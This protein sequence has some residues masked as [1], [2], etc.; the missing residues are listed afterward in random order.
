MYLSFDEWNVWYHSRQQDEET[1]KRDKWG[2]ALPLLEDIYNFEDALLVG[3]MLITLIRNS[4]RV[5]IACL[6]QLVNVIAPIMTEK[7]GGC[8]AQTIYWPFLHASLYGRGTAL[9]TLVESPHYDCRSRE[10]VPFVDAVAVRNEDGVTVFCVN[11]DM[12]EDCALSLDLR[13]FPALRIEEHILLHHDDV[14]AVNTSAAPDTVAPS[15]GPGGEMDGARA[16]LRI[17]ALSWNVI[18]LKK[19]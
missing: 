10:K 14:S 2:D 5:K 15:K 3:L 6:A 9:R 17:P 13:G 8:W 11:R 12:E 19:V 7:G 16:T 1:W 18:R 4:D